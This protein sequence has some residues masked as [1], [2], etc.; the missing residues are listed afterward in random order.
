[1]DKEKMRAYMPVIADLTRVGNIADSAL[2]D[3]IARFRREINAFRE[4]NHID[5]KLPVGEDTSPRALLA[6][7]FEGVVQDDIEKRNLEKYRSRVAELDAEEA[8]LRELRAQIK[9]LS[10]AKGPRDK[11]RLSELRTEA[12]ATANRIATLDKM[13]LRFEAS[14]PLQEVIKRK[15]SADRWR[16]QK[17]GVVLAVRHHSFFVAQTLRSDIDR[18]IHE[19]Y[20]PAVQLF[21]QELDGFPESLK[22]DDL[23]LPEELDHIVHIRIIAEPQDIVIG[24]AGFLLRP[25]ILD[26]VCHRIPLYLHT[27]SV[28]GGARC[29][30]RIN[31]HSMVDEIGGKRRFLD[32]AVLKIP[33]KLMN[34]RTDHFQ[35][36][37]F[38]RPYIRQ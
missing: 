2:A 15:R 11:A 18:R 32:L 25:H 8:K 28:P 19:I 16:I 7:A 35:M 24:H 5:Y 13:L 38:L 9:E 34:D 23:P 4:K 31:A 30:G 22:M 1:V 37:Q 10:F 17:R 3:N 26:Q 29:R 33:C 14:E 36:A 27:E 6:N 12:N 20:V 21:P